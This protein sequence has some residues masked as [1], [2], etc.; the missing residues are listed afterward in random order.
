MSRWT[1]GEIGELVK[2]FESATLPREA[3]TH[4]AHLAVALAYVREH[5]LEEATARM[6]GGIRRLNEALGGP[7]TAYHETVTRAY[8]TLIA[9]FAEKHDRGQ[10]FLELFRELLERCGDRTC[11]LRFYSREVLES[12]RARERWVTPDVRQISC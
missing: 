4:D 11:L 5:G 2:G 6:R 1:I 10:P 3:W 8:T 12:K 9:S 7:P